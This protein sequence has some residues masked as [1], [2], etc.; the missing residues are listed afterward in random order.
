MIEFSQLTFKSLVVHRV[1]NKLREEGILTAPELYG[2]G[3]EQLKNI[4]LD[5]FLLP[6]K[7]DEYYKFVHD[8]TLPQNDLEQYCHAIFEDRHAAFMEQSVHIARHLYNQSTH[9]KIH[10]GELYVA[11]F[12]DIQVEDELTDAIGIFKSEYKDIYLKTD[13]QNGR[14][15]LQCEKGINIKKLDKGCLIFNTFGHDGYRIMICD[16][17]AKNQGEAHYWKDQ[18]LHV[19]R[20]HDYSFNTE[21]LLNICREFSEEHYESEDA[22]KDQIVFMNKAINFFTQ[23]DHFDME[24]F[25]DEVLEEPKRIDEFKTY[26]DRYETQNNLKP[27]PDFKISQPAVKVAKRKFKSLIQL[28]TGIELRLKSE[29]TEQFIVKEYDKQRQMYYY[30]VYFTEE[31]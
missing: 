2:I 30:K 6:F 31:S 22:R 8:D 15:E 25:A 26:R 17:T 4:L 1:G 19:T 21:T 10:G 20:V 7:Q 3:D 9:P 12:S 16:R 24:E 23:R 27:V 28:D 13:E 14:V 29:Q 11:Y 18:F 5:Y